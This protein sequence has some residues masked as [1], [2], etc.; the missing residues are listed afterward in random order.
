M[1]NGTKNTHNVRYRHM[2]HVQLL[3]GES[4]KPSSY[5]A[6]TGMFDKIFV[7]GQAGIDRY[8]DH[9]VEIPSDRF[10]IVGR[11]QVYDITR[12]T[13]RAE[14]SIALYAPT[15]TGF[16]TDNNFGSLPVGVELVE[17]LL[18]AGWTV[19]FRPHPYSR[20]DEISQGQIAAIE[21]T[22]TKDASKTGR[23]HVFGMEACTTMTLTDCFNGSDVLVSDVSSVPADYLFS[24]KP[25][26]ITKMSSMATEAYLA[27][28]RLARAG[29]VADMSEGVGATA[30]IA[31]LQSDDK[32]ELRRETRI[33]YLGDIP[34]ENYE[35]CFIETARNIIDV[36]PSDTVSA[37]H[38]F[39]IEEENATDTDSVTG[40]EELSSDTESAEVEDQVD[41]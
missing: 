7:A 27:E 6:V 8:S 23:A 35:Q 37:A 32:S 18:A 17:A 33:H 9:G 20:R 34:A 26:V 14:R 39:S 15:W 16:H 10:E 31:Q 21:S 4:D 28:F 38:T 30:A 1:N 24:E 2:T 36:G 11:P 5:N 13:N 25:F 40:V 41:E 12:A 3:H 29:Y 19:I 22:L